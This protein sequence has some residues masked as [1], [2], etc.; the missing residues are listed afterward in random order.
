MYLLL[1]LLI[2]I[3][4]TILFF[5]T[6]KGRGI[7]GEFRVRIRIGKT[8]ERVQYVLNDLLIDTST[9]SC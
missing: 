8:K 9:K 6:P 4:I 3:L 2:I 5:K 7:I 1:I